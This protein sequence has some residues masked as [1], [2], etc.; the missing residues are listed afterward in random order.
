ME[1][2]ETYIPFC[3]GDF[4]RPGSDIQGIPLVGLW[5]LFRHHYNVSTSNPRDVTVQEH[6]EVVRKVGL[7][8]TTMLSVLTNVTRSLA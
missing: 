4:P 8:S 7:Y 3:P 1:N 2:F 5:F 6:V